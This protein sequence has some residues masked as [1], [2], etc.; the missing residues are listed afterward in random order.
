MGKWKASRKRRASEVSD[1]RGRRVSQVDPVALHLLNVPSIIPA[2]TLRAMTDE[3]LPGARRRRFLQVAATLSGILLVVGGNIVYF[4]CFSVWKG[5]DPVLGGVYLVQAV[6]ILSG[7]LLAYRTVR[8]QYASNVARVML[9]HGHCP[10]CGYNLTGLPIA[11]ND[12]LT[13][14]PECGCAW[15]LGS[16]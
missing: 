12:G 8:S 16:A 10:H 5:L 11:A 9:A 13:V 2:E 7:P 1:A 3:I 14:C 4:R 6:I 15:A